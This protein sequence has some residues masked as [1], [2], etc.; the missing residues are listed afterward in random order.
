MNPMFD[1]INAATLFDSAL[2]LTTLQAPLDE[3]IA[4]TNQAV[5]GS[6][7]FTQVGRLG[8][9]SRKWK[10]AKI[11]PDSIQ[12][13]KQFQTIPLI[14]STD[15]LNHQKTTRK[16]RQ[17]LL[18]SPKTWVASQG[19]NA[20]HKWSPMTL[21]DVARWFKRIQ[22]CQHICGQVKSENGALV[23]SINKPMPY[24]SNAISYLWERVD[25]FNGKEKLEFIIAA[26]SMLPRNHWDRFA[27][28][29][30][31]DWLMSSVEDA[32]ELARVIVEEYQNQQVRE[33][34][35]NLRKGIF[36]GDRDSHDL[37]EIIDS[38]GLKEIFSIYF[39]A[40]CREMYCECC[41]HTGLHI[42]MDNLI[43]EIIPDHLQS[44]S[45]QPGAPVLLETAPENLTGEYVVTVFNEALPLI[46]YRTGD[47]IRLISLDPCACG[48]TH[49]RVEFL[50]RCTE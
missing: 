5:F 16:I 29:K 44:L 17:N 42:W 12:D 7:I 39:S 15:L 34:F 10:Q 45:P 31:P 9:Y 11:H 33:L 20:P 13:R 43:H 23:L 40:E 32:R 1:Q 6:N 22:I 2:D 28:Q 49:P 3:L 36:W 41:N 38:Y 27:I 47:R 4:K 24:A 46:R 19:K 8:I 21:N 30:R 26:M 35:P 37:T 14:D 50:G 48:I 18:D 25:Y